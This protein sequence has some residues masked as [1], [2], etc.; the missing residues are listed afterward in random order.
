MGIVGKVHSQ[1]SLGFFGDELPISQ[2]TMEIENVR[3]D[4]PMG[5]QHNVEPG[6]II[7]TV[8]GEPFT[9]L[10]RLGEI[11]RGCQDIT[12]HVARLKDATDLEAYVS[13]RWCGVVATVSLVF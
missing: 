7:L 3:A 2:P 6:D 11:S 5:L 8:N 4:S 10:Q 13:L 9:T 12:F 1:V